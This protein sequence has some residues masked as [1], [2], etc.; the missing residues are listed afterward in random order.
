MKKV[1]AVLLLLAS[2]F[3]LAIPD[4]VPFID[5]GLLFIIL[6][7]SL[8]MLGLDLKRFVG[9]KSSKKKGTEKPIDIN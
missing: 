1:F 4:P 6:I 8:S 7:N 2:V 5:E 9:M 3:G